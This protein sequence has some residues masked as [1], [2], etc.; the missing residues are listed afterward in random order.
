MADKKP[1]KQT[2]LLPTTSRKR[3]IVE[4]DTDTVKFSKPIESA[5]LP[6]ARTLPPARQNKLDASIKKKAAAAAPEKALKSRP[7]LISQE[8]IRSQFCQLKPTDVDSKQQ[9]QLQCYQKYLCR[10]I[11]E[12]P[13]K[14]E[15]TFFESP[16]L[17]F[18]PSNLEI[19][20]FSKLI[21]GK[22]TELHEKW[23]TSNE[24]DKKALREALMAAEEERYEANVSEVKQLIAENRS[25]FISIYEHICSDLE[26]ARRTNTTLQLSIEA[27]RFKYDYDYK[28]I[29]TFPKF[30][31]LTF[32]GIKY[33]SYLLL[34]T[35]DYMYPDVSIIPLITEKTMTFV[36]KDYKPKTTSLF[37]VWLESVNQSKIESESIFTITPNQPILREDTSQE[38]KASCEGKEMTDLATMCFRVSDCVSILT[39]SQ[40]KKME[41]IP[42]K[43][44]QSAQLFPEKLRLFLESS[45]KTLAANILTVKNANKVLEFKTG[46]C[47]N[48][49]DFIRW[50]NFDKILPFC[51]IDL[52]IEDCKKFVDI[53]C[54]RE[55]NRRSQSD[56]HIAQLEAIK[57]WEEIVGP[58]LLERDITLPIKQP[59]IFLK[60]NTETLSK[61][62]EYF[63]SDNGLKSIFRD[64]GANPY[65]IPSEDPKQDM[66]LLP[67]QLIPSISHLDAGC[68]AGHLYEAMQ[69]VSM[70]LYGGLITVEVKSNN[71]VLTKDETGNKKTPTLS[72][73][74]ATSTINLQ[75]PTKVKKISEIEIRLVSITIAARFNPCQG[76][77]Q[78]AVDITIGGNNARKATS[79]G[80]HLLPTIIIT[81]GGSKTSITLT[82][83]INIDSM[84]AEILRIFT[85]NNLE[86][87]KAQIL[88]I[89]KM[90]ITA[91]KQTGD[92]AVLHS[93]IVPILYPTQTAVFISV[94]LG[95]E[96]V[97]WNRL[98]TGE[99]KFVPIIC[100]FS[101][102]KNGWTITE[103]ISDPAI[104]NKRIYDNFE[105]C[106]KILL[107]DRIMDAGI[108]ESSTR[109]KT[110]TEIE[111]DVFIALKEC[112]KKTVSCI[113]T[114]PEDLIAQKLFDTMHSEKIRSCKELMSEWKDEIKHILQS[115]QQT[116]IDQ[117]SKYNILSIIQPITDIA[118]LFMPKSNTF[119][120]SPPNI[121]FLI[122]LADV[123]EHLIECN[124]IDGELTLTCLIISQMDT[125]GIKFNGITI[126]STMSAFLK[127]QQKNQSC[128]VSCGLRTDHSEEDEDPDN[129]YVI[130]YARSESKNGESVRS[131]AHSYNFTIPVSKAIEIIRQ[132]NATPEG[133]RSGNKKSIF[134]NLTHG[135]YT[136][137]QSKGYSKSEEEFQQLIVSIHIEELQ[138][139][140]QEQFNQSSSVGMHSAMAAAAASAASAS[141]ASFAAA[142]AA[143]PAFSSAAPASAAF[144]APAFKID[145][146]NL[147]DGTIISWMDDNGTNRGTINQSI[148][149]HYIII[150][151]E[152]AFVSIKKDSTIKVIS[153]QGR[154]IKTNKKSKKNRRKINI[155]KTKKNKAKKYRLT[156]V[157]KH[158]NKVTKVKQ[159]KYKVKKLNYTQKR[160]PRRIPRRIPRRQTKRR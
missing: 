116:P 11:K 58:I 20:R 92:L 17:K 47:D 76:I 41:P 113:L 152:G 26:F 74:I 51:D 8:D 154:G 46:V 19:K 151:D 1:T 158:K 27:V 2:N 4:P 39:S 62:Q 122:S 73:S 13:T 5:K 104:N 141:F 139:N 90:M 97:L 91:Y 135:L 105:V 49:H 44:T 79:D 129:D 10:D 111:V 75:I 107:D 23:K 133:R 45:D 108:L 42:S 86:I 99:A 25:N 6:P 144:F 121:T 14:G 130:K 9:L 140:N 70:T 109:N 15:L 80:V 53:M 68:G 115:H 150:S 114:K 63:G 147:E 56:V 98:R 126:P 159:N 85:D 48:I 93:L 84:A 124:V 125:D 88:I 143:A 43:Y 55:G 95:I 82:S 81:I 96:D 69:N 7:I 128:P 131:Q 89:L 72:T 40:S 37:N 106:S 83:E 38:T 102:N 142:P 118:T 34:K 132:V 36:P 50:Q 117:L 160:R 153:G 87:N 149:D 31:I 127:Q 103:G 35:G 3:S 28:G 134:D 110:Y 64:T 78:S 24:Q 148:Q 32:N 16:T 21:H 155:K 65:K 77:S 18:T 138:R 33:V 157:N 66:S 61:M 146:T 71:N 30:M 137:L 112:L 119:D 101:G 145:T 67:F 120:W 123:G 156:K 12:E 94:D 52:S 60:R 100:S 57:E 136:I 22:Y 29:H 59:S 54:N